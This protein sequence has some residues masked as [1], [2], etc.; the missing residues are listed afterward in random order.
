M[1]EGEIH[2]DSRKFPYEGNVQ[3]TLMSIIFKSSVD[4]RHLMDRIL[5]AIPLVLEHMGSLRS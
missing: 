1:C 5:V 2:S 4:S 3:N